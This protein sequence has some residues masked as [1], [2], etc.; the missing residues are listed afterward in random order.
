MRPLPSPTRTEGDG[1]ENSE[2]TKTE[3]KVLKRD[4]FTLGDKLIYRPQ[5]YK[6][7]SP[8]P[9]LIVGKVVNLVPK[10]VIK[11]KKDTK[12]LDSLKSKE[13]KFVPYEPYKA[14]VKSMIPLDK[15]NRLDRF[16]SKKHIPEVPSLSAKP[17]DKKVDSAEA[18]SLERKISLDLDVLSMKNV[19]QELETERESFIL[20][21]KTLKEENTQLESQLKFQAQV[22]GELKAL[23]VAAVG[24]DLEVRV[25]H[26]TEDKLQL[27]RALLNSAQKLSTHQ[28]QTEWLAGQC[29][30]GLRDDGRLSP[31]KGMATSIVA[32]DTLLSASTVLPKPRWQ[33]T[34]RPLTGPY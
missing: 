17:E 21:L 31:K 16:M 32:V 28:E 1:M 19:I 13:P 20:E 6:Q 8:S 24:E 4:K 26:L 10:N 30:K 27:A 5:D 29:E 25:N 15:K 22:N 2:T 3:N 9:P 12:I 11:L 33:L 23:L 34:A 7:Y 14:A 18:I